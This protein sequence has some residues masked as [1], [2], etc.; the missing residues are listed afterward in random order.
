MRQSQRSI[1]HWQAARDIHCG[2][3]IAESSQAGERIEL[4]QPA[5]A[6]QIH[7]SESKTSLAKSLH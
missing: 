2:G 3:S 5:A 1:G 4:N 7:T 6:D